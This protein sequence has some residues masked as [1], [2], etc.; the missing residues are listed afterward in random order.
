MED[1]ILKRHILNAE[2]ALNHGLAVFIEG[3]RGTGKHSTV[4]E[5]NRALFKK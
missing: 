1:P 2:N 3:K 5:L 4:V